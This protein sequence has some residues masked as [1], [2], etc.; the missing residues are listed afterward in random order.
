MR[1]NQRFIEDP[2]D[3]NAMIKDIA[4]K[5]HIDYEDQEML[6]SVEKAIDEKNKEK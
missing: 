1:I 5:T 6:N 4:S 3:E 2:N